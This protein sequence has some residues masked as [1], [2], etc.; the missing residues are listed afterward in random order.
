MARMHP[1]ELPECPLMETPIS[2][3]DGHAAVADT[4]FEMSWLAKSAENAQL[5]GEAAKRHRTHD[6]FSHHGR[7][8]TPI[9]VWEN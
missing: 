6:S 1:Q 7:R 2:L 3:H 8:L 9:L 5:A 4:A